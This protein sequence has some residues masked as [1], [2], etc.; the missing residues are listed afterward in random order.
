MKP[1]KTGDKTD[2]DLIICRCEGVRIE[3]IQASILR[4]GAQTVNQVKKLTRAGMGLCQGRT[5]AKL[6]ETLLV[7]NGTAPAGAEPYQARPPVRA[8]PVGTLAAASDQFEEPEGP[9]RVD[10]TRETDLNLEPL[11]PEP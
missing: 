9:V 5:C 2:A 11:N 3:Q 4:S 6:V 10:L 8:V 7:S 1:K